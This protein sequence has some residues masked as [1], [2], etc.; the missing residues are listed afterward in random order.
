LPPHSIAGGSL[1]FMESLHDSQ[2]AHW[3]HERRRLARSSGFSRPDVLPPEGGTPCKSRFME[4]SEHRQL[5][6]RAAQ[7]LPCGS[8][9][10]L[11]EFALNKGG[12]LR[13]DV[14]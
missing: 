1:S 13:D 2:I 5:W 12:A 11:F 3:G 10:L 4:R 7:S 6:E 14:A 9:L 8:L